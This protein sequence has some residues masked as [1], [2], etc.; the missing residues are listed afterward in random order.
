[1]PLLKQF[2]TIADNS[3]PVISA[4]PSLSSTFSASWVGARAERERMNNE[5]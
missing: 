5:P 2:L 4:L 1:M 3:R